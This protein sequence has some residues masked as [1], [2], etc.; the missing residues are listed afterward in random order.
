M[1]NFKMSG[2][3]FL[4]IKFNITNKKLSSLRLNETNSKLMKI[5]QDNIVCW[6]LQTD[7]KNREKISR[8]YNVIRL[9]ETN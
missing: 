2:S 1:A 3:F 5:I 4:I 8:P 7:E 9:Y 6:T